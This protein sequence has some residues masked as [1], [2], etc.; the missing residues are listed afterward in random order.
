MVY[1]DTFNCSGGNGK[2]KFFLKIGGDSVTYVY[3]FESS[4][5]DNYVDLS[6]DY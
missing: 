3:R 6:C 5:P 1:E 4:Q 2:Q